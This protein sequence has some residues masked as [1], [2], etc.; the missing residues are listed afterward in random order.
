MKTKKSV[1]K[2]SLRQLQIELVSLQRHIISHDLRVLVLFEGRDASGKDGVIKAI[3]EHLSPRETRVVAL[4][5]PNERENH[6]WYFQRYVAHL[7][8]DGEMVLFNRSWYNRAGV[9]KVM[10]FCTDEEYET[11]MRTVDDFEHLL[12]KSGITLLK[13]YLDIDRAEQSRRLAARR[14]DPLTQW[15]ISPID[16]TALKHFK[17][18]SK[19]RDAM[20]ERTH[21]DA[22]PWTIVDANDKETARLN[23]IRDILR[24]VPCSRKSKHLQKPDPQILYRYKP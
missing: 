19:A 10:G 21:S 20:F 5:K 23:V 4:G 6:S 24:R 9:E 13:Y 7:P 14:K 2:R 16:R 22:A 3:S 1:Y 11:F 12:I 18:Y 15:K 17:A 8:A